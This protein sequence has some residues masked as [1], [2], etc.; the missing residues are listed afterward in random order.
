[1]SVT[2]KQQYIEWAKIAEKAG[3]IND[4][5]QAIN[6]A[7]ETGEELTYLEMVTLGWIYDMVM[8][9]KKA[10][11]IAISSMAEEY[12][13]NLFLVPNA[14]T[15]EAQVWCLQ[16]K[17]NYCKYLADISEGQQKIDIVLEAHKAYQAGFDASTEQLSPLHHARLGLALS[18]SIFCNDVLKQNEEAKC[19]AKQDP[20]P[21]GLQTELGGS[22]TEPGGSQTEPGGSQ[23]EPEGS[24][25]EPE[26]LQTEPEGSQTKPEGS[27]TEPEG[28]QSEPEDSELSQKVQKLNKKAQKL[29][30]KAQKLT[31]KAHKLSQKKSKSESSDI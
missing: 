5:V 4:A 16:M 3:R 6:C 24:Q 31:E 19:L 21:E 11:W 17:G 22:Q 14:T 7:V 23:T 9:S 28:S 8:G 29:S 26:G 10:A 30:K 13:L 12:L 1:M 15:V 27:L 2:K 25:T 18:Y 20:E